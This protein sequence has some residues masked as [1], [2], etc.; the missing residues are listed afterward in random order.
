[1]H[2]VII[3]DETIDGLNSLAAELVFFND[4]APII[5]KAEIIE[6]NA[7]SATLTTRQCVFKG[8]NIGLNIFSLTKQCAEVFKLEEKVNGTVNIRVMAE[9]D[10]SE[11]IPIEESAYKVHVSFRSH[12]RVF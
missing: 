9:V 11:K 2:K 4:G 1:M 6:L 5:R 7:E 3:R 8:Q 12:I 10:T